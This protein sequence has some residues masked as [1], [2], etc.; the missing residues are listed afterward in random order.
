M[1]EKSKTRSDFAHSA[2]LF[3]FF[4]LLQLIFILFA[5][6]DQKQGALN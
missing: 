3:L 6:G 5:L 4:Y 1:A 2:T